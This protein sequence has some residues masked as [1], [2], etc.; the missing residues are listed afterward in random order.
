MYSIHFIPNNGSD[1]TRRKSA[2]FIHT[3]TYAIH[4]RILL[5]TQNNKDI[6]IV[7]FITASIR[8]TH[9]HVTTLAEWNLFVIQ[10]NILLATSVNNTHIILLFLSMYISLNVER[11]TFQFKQNN[12]NGSS[13]T[14]MIEQERWN[15]KKG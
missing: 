9:R 7:I 2:T 13:I 1:T 5:Q 12:G 10:W 8:S 4:E 3:K 15:K 14:F 6:I 11:K